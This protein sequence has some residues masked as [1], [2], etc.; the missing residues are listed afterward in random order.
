MPT[1]F[2]EKTALERQL[3]NMVISAEIEQRRRQREAEHERFIN[4]QLAKSAAEK[5][6]Q[7]ENKH[8][9]NSILG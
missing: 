4:E 8:L 3:E 5:A 7:I 9:L 1:T 2:T 6:K